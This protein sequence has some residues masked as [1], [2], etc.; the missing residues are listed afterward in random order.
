MSDV[1]EL[2]EVNYI[3]MVYEINQGILHKNQIDLN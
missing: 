1:H 2:R 3:V